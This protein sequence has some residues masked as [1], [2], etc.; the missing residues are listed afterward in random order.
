MN[1][2]VEGQEFDSEGLCKTC[3]SQAQKQKIDW[4]ARREALGKIFADA[5]ANAG[6]NYDCI[7]PISGGKDSTWQ[8]HVLVKEYGMKPLAVTFS[9]NWFSKTGWYNLMNSLEKF[10]LDH[11]MFTPGRELVNRCARHS[12]E[13][14]GDACW[15]CHAG[16]AAFVLKMAVAYKIPLI[17]WGEST[18]EHGR[19]T[20]D[21]PDKFDRDYFLR[22]S[23]KFT[24]EQF[25]CE[26]LSLR[27]LFPFEVPSAEECE[28]IGLNGIHLGDYIFWDTEKQVKFIKNKYGWK[29]TRIEGAY[30]DYKSAECSMAGIHDFLCYLKRGY[31]RASIQA[32]ED[33]RAGWMTREEGFELA[34][35]YERI[36][37]KSISYFLGITGMTFGELIYKL[38]PL[39]HEKMYENGGSFS[40]EW[41]DV[42]E[43]GKPFAQRLIDGEE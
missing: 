7:V 10:N 34:K 37:P 3:Q 5:K 32:S 19:A 24:N 35:K 39:A 26:Y 21:K 1:E 29:G 38:E 43:A 31:C 13:T 33:I 8:M 28:A 16:V 20:Y 22:V 27:D 23:A 41:R 30:K 11:V 15:H 42:P 2:C 17:V 9:H 40:E 6:N 18:A 14:I 36:L 12:V 25:A 4:P